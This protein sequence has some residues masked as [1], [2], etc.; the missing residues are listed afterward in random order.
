M[1]K[2]EWKKKLRALVF[3]MPN[4]SAKWIAAHAI[5]VKGPSCGLQSVKAILGCDELSP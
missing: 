3:G 2:Q 5:S 4:S 1:A